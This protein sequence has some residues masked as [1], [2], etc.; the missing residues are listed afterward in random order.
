MG[1]AGFDLEGNLTIGAVDMN[2]AAWAVI[3]DERGQGG[4]INLWAGFDVRG[5][6]RL[7]PSATGVIAY[8]R[9]MT[10]TRHDLRLLVVGDVDSAGAPVSN[11]VAGL[12]AN[13][14]YL[15]ANVVAPVVSS[16]G[17]RAATLLMPSGA[18]RTANIHVLGLVT[19][20]YALSV[21]I[22]GCSQGALWIGTLQISI[23]GGRFS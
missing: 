12:Q 9:R 11:P 13:L 23:P 20:S 16:T 5:E 7:L 15:R 14:E 8:P 2:Q 4:L 10:A 6:D 19:Q 17:T 3:G 18:T 1:L 22:D 21:V